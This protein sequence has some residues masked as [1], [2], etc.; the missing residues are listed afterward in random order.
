M[1][2]VDACARIATDTCYVAAA[3]TAARCAP[4]F[5]PCSA[6]CPIHRIGPTGVN[7]HM[8][9]RHKESATVCERGRRQAEKP[10]KGFEPLTCA[11][12]KHRSDQL[13]YGGKCSY[14][15]DLAVVLEEAQI[16]VV[17]QLVRSTSQKPFRGPLH[18]ACIDL[19]VKRH[20]GLGARVSSPL[21]NIAGRVPRLRPIVNTTLAHRMQRLG[22]RFDLA[23]LQ[24][25]LKSRSRWSTHKARGRSV[26]SG[27][28]VGAEQGVSHG[29]YNS[30]F[31]P[32]SISY[33][34]R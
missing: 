14:S 6:T 26:H 28:L 9:A 23:C 8:P 16:A 10:P 2:P 4:K 29:V 13:S 7:L 31:S 25:F 24:S 5:R 19:T 32:V 20:R 1:P 17:A 12:R 30:S 3:A 18:I 27:R 22:V 21:L 33:A 34:C 15:S 11:L